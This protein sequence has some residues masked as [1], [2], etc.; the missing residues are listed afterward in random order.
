MYNII[1]RKTEKNDDEDDFILHF[2][3]DFIYYHIITNGE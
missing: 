1:S 2:L 3:I